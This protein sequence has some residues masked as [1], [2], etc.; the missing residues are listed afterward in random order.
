MGWVGAN[1]IGA[2]KAPKNVCIGLDTTE[3]LG[4]DQ[5]KDFSI[6]QFGLRPVGL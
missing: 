4:Q 2:S 6:R 5:M 1:Q 3:K